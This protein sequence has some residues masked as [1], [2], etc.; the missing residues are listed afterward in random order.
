[1]ALGCSVMDTCQAGATSD[2]FSVVVDSAGEFRGVYKAG[3]SPLLDTQ[4]RQCVEL[5]KARGQYVADLLAAA[6]T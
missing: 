1:M 3:G 4:L 6:A 5:A 2:C